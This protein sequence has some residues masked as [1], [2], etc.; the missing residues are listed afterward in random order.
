[1]NERPCI[2]AIGAH[3]AD[4]EFTAGATLLKHARNG[5]DAHII[6]LT[7]GEKGDPHLSPDEYGA[8]KRREAEAAAQI[9]QATPHFLPY[10]DGELT[11]GDDIA[12][13]LAKWLRRLRP[14]VI[15]THWRDS[16]HSDH[17][18]TYFLVRRALF[19][20][21]N[22][23]FDLDGLP[24]ARGMRL[25]Y[26]ENWED[27]ENFRPFVYVDI[28]K[29]F[30]DWERAFKCFAIGRGEGGFPY[31]DWYQACTRLRGIEIGVPYAQAFAID[32]WRMRQRRE[33]L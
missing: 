32:E 9:L 30:P 12:R 15:I 6:H 27:A 24:P 17:T 23:H 22:P 8:Q 31:W 21:A 25:Y 19:L 10:R 28:S 13:E 20:A 26:A 33:T 4:M 29:V 14:Q 7:L 5:W 16:I 3:A 18:A 2:V 1:M 11:V